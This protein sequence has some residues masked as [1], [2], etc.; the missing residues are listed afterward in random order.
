MEQEER[1]PGTPV[2]SE[3]TP[4]LSMFE[5]EEDLRQLEFPPPPPPWNGPYPASM[6]RSERHARSPRRW[7]IAVAAGLIGVIATLL[8]T[9]PV[10]QRAIADRESRIAQLT[11]EFDQAQAEQQEVSARSAEL[12][13]RQTALDQR[14]RELD[15]RQAALDQREREQPVS[16]QA[17][18]TAQR[19]HRQQDSRQAVSTAQRE[20]RQQDSRRVAPDRPVPMPGVDLPEGAQARDMFS[21]LPQGV[22]D[23]F[24]KFIPGY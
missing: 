14:E 24:G 21:H 18:P 16:R 2:E 19:E 9:E 11:S 23:F 4:R 13:D 3:P 20:R 10:L 8:V 1:I 15:D 6:R 12:D 22:P 5:E 17:M 7:P